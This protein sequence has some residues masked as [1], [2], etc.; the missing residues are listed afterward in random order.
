V[1][2]AT[3]SRAVTEVVLQCSSVGVRQ[4]D[5]C[6][7]GGV[8][9]ET[10]RQHT[11]SKFYL[12]GFA[13]EREQLSRVALPG[14]P[15]VRLSIRD[16]TVIKDFYSV[17]LPG[18]ERSDM[19]EKMFSEIE[20]PASRGLD[21]ILG[22]AWPLSREDKGSLA[23]WI[24]LQQLRGEE[25]RASQNQIG[26]DFIRLLVGVSGKQALRRR[27]EAAEGRVVGDQELD[28]EWRDITKPGGPTIM[29]NPIG[30]LRTVVELAPGLGE[31]LRD[32]HW[33][34]HRFRRR[35]LVTCDHPVSMDQADRRV[36]DGVGLATADL[37]TVALSRRLALTIQPR[38][39]LERFT[40]EP[41]SV[42]DFDVDGTTASA[43][44]V[45]QQTVLEARR[46][47]YLHPEDDL[48]PRIHLPGRT[49]TSRMR[50]IGIDG[51]ISEEGLG[52]PDGSRLPPS[53]FP[54][55]DLN[56]SDGVTLDDLPWPIPGRIRP[57]A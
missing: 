32:S 23:L 8:M 15:R 6:E 39:R 20:G 31:Y 54:S 10:R 3:G 43:N 33:T 11:V 38:R 55:E 5:A 29:P 7:G 27:I 16:A 25:Q 2:S 52:A 26:T 56:G 49:S 34:L 36:G 48:D 24:A 37:F 46:Y 35:A 53:P 40:A 1:A 21:A 28:F 47:V 22:G 13:D 19:F 9:Q 51:L 42:A 44:S 4:G 41:G 50:G 30:H 57:G 45:N 12:R 17:E 18:G 14:T